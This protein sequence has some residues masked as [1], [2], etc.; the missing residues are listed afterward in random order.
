MK[1]IIYIVFLILICTKTLL[2][3]YLTNV[4][5]TL[6]QPNGDTLHCFASGDEFYLRLHDINNYTIVQDSHTG[7]FVYGILNNGEVTASPWIAGKSN[8]ATKGIKPGICISQEKYLQRRQKYIIPAKREVERNDQT[9]HG[10]INNLSIFIRFSDDTNFTANFSYVNNLFNDTSLNYTTNSMFNYFKRTSYNQLFIRTYFYPEAQGENILSYQD[11]FPRSYFLPWSE[12]NPNGYLEGER[13]EREHA[14]LDRACAFVDSLI[15]NNINFDYNNDGY[16]D[17]VVFIIKGGVGDWNVLLWPHRWSL[18][19]TNTYIHGKRIYDYNIQLYDSPVYFNTSVLCHEMFHSLGAPDLYHYN[20]VDG[21]VPCG[22]W[23]LMAQNQNPPQQTCAYMKYKYGNWIKESEIIP[24]NQPGT[25]TLFPLNSESVDRICYRI[26]TENPWEYILA[27]YR[28][29]QA[30]FDNT[31]PNRGVVFYRINTLSHGNSGYNGTD[32]F[33]EVYVFR[34]NGTTEI[35][36]NI[37]AANFRGNT[38]RQDFSPSTNPYPFLSNGDTVPVRFTNFTHSIDSIQFDFMP[39]VSIDNYYIQNM[40][41]Y[42]NPATQQFTIK[43]DEQGAYTYQLYNSYG[44]IINT[45]Y[46]DQQPFSFSVHHYPAGYYF[47]K[48]INEQGK[49]K[50]IKFVK[51]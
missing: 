12:T 5:R 44:Q 18:Y 49:S 35:N 6:I 16:I 40:T 41:A 33:D 39:W 42:P 21:I 46:S 9:N 10:N 20:D 27:D 11:T 45:F 48:I 28:S 1:K 4:P 38:V 34:A 22:A 13:T 43:T 47:I 30:P 15:P 17:N 23:D 14:L 32:N 26:E 8:P 29:K 2:G 37:N 50:T 31:C 24:I 3:A 36:G 51:Q 25:Y 19:S 7:Y